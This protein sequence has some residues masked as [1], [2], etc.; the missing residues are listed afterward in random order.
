[1]S[2]SEIVELLDGSAGDPAT[3]FRN[4]TALT[5]AALAVRSDL[6]DRVWRFAAKG[7]S[8]SAGHEHPHFL[9]SECGTV[10]CMP[11]LELRTRSGQR[12]PRSVRNLDAE[13]QIKGLC[14]DCADTA[15]V[16][17]N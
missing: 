14:D 1:M 10:E 2:H 15:D 8:A 9:C 17:R 16:S 13:V 7:S 4:L 5:E 6:G 12:V 11:S 3:V